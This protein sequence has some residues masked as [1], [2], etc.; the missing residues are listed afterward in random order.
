M[1]TRITHTVDNNISK[2]FDEITKKKGFNKSKV[3][4]LLIEKWIKENE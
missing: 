3:V 2:K 1:K 4:Q